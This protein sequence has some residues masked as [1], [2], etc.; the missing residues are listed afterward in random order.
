MSNNPKPD[1]DRIAHDP[2]SCNLATAGG[3]ISIGIEAGDT[4]TDAV[5]YDSAQ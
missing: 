5:I 4:Y 3:F 1:S 2:P